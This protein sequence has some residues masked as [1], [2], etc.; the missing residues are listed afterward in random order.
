MKSTWKE[1]EH[2][3]FP[4]SENLDKINVKELDYCSCSFG[5]Q[6]K[7]QRTWSRNG[8]PV[9]AVHVQLCRASALVQG[10]IETLCKQKMIMLQMVLRSCNIAFT[11]SKL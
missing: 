5:F 11:V 4:E 6:H 9:L 1:E 3:L 10:L 8:C 7:C 2:V